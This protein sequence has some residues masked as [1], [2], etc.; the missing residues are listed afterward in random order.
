MP[1]TAVRSISGPEAREL[2]ERGWGC[3]AGPPDVLHYDPAAGH[4]S[5]DFQS[6]GDENATLMRPIPAESPELKGR[7]ER[8]IDFWK[9]LWEKVNRDQQLKE[10][11]S[12]HAVCSIISWVCNNHL[13][14]S[15]NHQQN[16]SKLSLDE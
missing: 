1:S 12:I 9:D 10:D 8:A 14:K 2:F 11:D 7:I 15:G 3:W 13:R 6:A 16:G 4:L 5:E